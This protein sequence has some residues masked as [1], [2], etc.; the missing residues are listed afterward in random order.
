MKIINRI[1][2]NTTEFIKGRKGTYRAIV[3]VQA[4]FL[5]IVDDLGLQANWGRQQ[6]NSGIEV[7]RN[8]KKGALQSIQ[9]KLEGTDT[10][11]TVFGMKGRKVVL[12]DEDILADI[13]VGDINQCWYNTN[14]YD[15]TQYSTVGAKH[16]G[17]Y[18]FRF[19][20]VEETVEA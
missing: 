11:L 8:F 4:G 20:E 9:F 6:W 3:K 18:A 7:F 14:L 10:W 15:Q 13:T 17:H 5:T 1:G 19:N 12:I 16:W 2:L